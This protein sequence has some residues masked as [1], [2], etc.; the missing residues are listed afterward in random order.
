MI[1]TNLNINDIHRKVWRDK[2][3]KKKKDIELI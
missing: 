2:V 1:I 3:Y